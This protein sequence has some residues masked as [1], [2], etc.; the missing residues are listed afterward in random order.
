VCKTVDILFIHSSADGHLG[1]FYL[2]GIVN[3]AATNIG[4]QMLYFGSWGYQPVALLG[5]GRTLRRYSLVERSGG[6]PLKE[7]L[8]P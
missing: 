1:C 5:A 4:K 3:N 8:G 2:L 6:V 7:M